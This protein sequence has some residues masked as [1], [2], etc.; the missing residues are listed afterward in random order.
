MS[1]FGL[2]KKARFTFAALSSSL[3][4][5]NYCHMEPILA[6][7]LAEKGLNTVQIGLFF[8]IFPL[9]YIPCSTL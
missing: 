7:R 5:F 9:A 4:E 6:P 3:A 1:Y 2:L 8:A